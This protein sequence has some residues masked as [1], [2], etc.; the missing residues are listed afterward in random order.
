MSDAEKRSRKVGSGSNRCRKTLPESWERFEY[1][2]RCSSLVG[3]ITAYNLCGSY[4]ACF[5]R[6]TCLRRLAE[7]YA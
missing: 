3:F 5:A 4:N 1:Q 6:Y 2:I 7:S